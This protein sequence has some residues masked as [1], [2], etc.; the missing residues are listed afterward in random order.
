MNPAVVI[1]TYWSSS[2]RLGNP[3]GVQC[4]DHA[5]PIE[6]ENPQ[7]DA[8]LASLKQ[9]LGLKTVIILVTAPPAVEERA[10]RRVRELADKHALEDVVIVDS[11]KAMVLNEKIAGELP[12]DIGEPI[13]LRGYGAIR[14]M[15]LLACCA[16]GCD[17]AVFIDD[18][19]T[20]LDENFLVNAVYGFGQVDRNGLPIVAKSGYFLDR[21]NS[22]LADRRTVQFYDKFWAKR[23]EFNQWMTQALAGPRISR[24]NVLCGGCFA[25]HAQAFTRIAFDPWITRGEDLD[26]LIN[27]RLYGMDVWFDNRWRVRH[28]PPRIKDKAPRFLQDVY[29]WTYE[30]RKIEI[31]N[32]N[33]D[34]HML[35]PEALMP[36][37]GPWISAELPTRIRKTAYWRALMTNEKAAYWDIYRKGRKDAE[38]YAEQNCTNYLHFQQVWPVVTEM[39]WLDEEMQHVLRGAG[40][41]SPA[42]AA[43]MAQRAGMVGGA[44]GGA[45]AAGA[46]PAGAAGV[47]AGVGTGGFAAAGVQSE[48]GEQSERDARH[49]HYVPVASELA[50][51]AEGYGA[52]GVPGAYDSAAAGANAGVPG[53]A[54]APSWDDESDAPLSADDLTAAWGSDG[55]DVP[56]WA[57][58]S[59]PRVA[60]DA[61][62]DEAP[63]PRDGLLDGEPADQ[64]PVS[65]RPATEADEPGAASE[66]APASPDAA[67]RRPTAPTAS[68]SPAGPGA[69]RPDAP[70][71]TD[72]E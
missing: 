9:V 3:G 51:D 32:S 36:Y 59:Q 8:C 20:V 22:A 58:G 61:A 72:A 45:P 1:P 67:S 50:G 18:D 64:Y 13:S 21:R 65:A 44:E 11:F 29:R 47:E 17:V 56:A 26:Y 12:P 27:M 4:Y 53:T 10:V 42:I 5:T 63:A 60:V 62:D 23:A 25:V 57:T 41:L 71:P 16:L 24:S 48:W 69:A 7:L 28:M 55:E 19:E 49:E 14:N 6:S 35:T 43:R 15:G 34:M 66:P 68:Q 70:A 38:D 54:G 2:D 46:A 31:C 39:A 37:P 40:M 30:R 52:D 33:I